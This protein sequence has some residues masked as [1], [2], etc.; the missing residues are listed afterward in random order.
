MD[1]VK[2]F[3]RRGAEAEERGEARPCRRD[4]DGR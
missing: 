4:A 3:G 2:N 1:E